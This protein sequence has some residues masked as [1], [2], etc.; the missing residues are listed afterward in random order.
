MW[1]NKQQHFLDC[2]YTSVVGYSWSVETW[3]GVGK[4]KKK[5]RRNCHLN[6]FSFPIH[7]HFANMSTTHD[8]NSSYLTMLTVWPYYLNINFPFST[9]FTI[10]TALGNRLSSVYLFEPSTFLLCYVVKAKGKAGK[11]LFYSS[12]DSVSRELTQ[13]TIVLA[14]S[15]LYH[16][17][18][19]SFDHWEM[20][21]CFEFFVE[22]RISWYLTAQKG[23]SKSAQVWQLWL[24]LSCSIFFLPL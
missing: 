9:E 2:G 6:D 8:L 14:C 7:S 4:R 16:I 1:Q 20:S 24:W 10:L 23:T 17:P 15:H 22:D 12:A 5:R 18:F 19:K 13:E 11:Q 3:Y 21:Q